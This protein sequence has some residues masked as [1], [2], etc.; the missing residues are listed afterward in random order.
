MQVLGLSNFVSP[1]Y[2]RMVESNFVDNDVTFDVRCPGTIYL[3]RNY[4]GET[5]KSAASMTSAEILEAIRDG[6]LR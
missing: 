4:Y 6:G 5:R 2:F 1:Y 3:Y